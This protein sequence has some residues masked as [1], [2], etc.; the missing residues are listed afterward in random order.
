MG[1]WAGGSI[2]ALRE[3]QLESARPSCS[4]RAPEVVFAQHMK[5]RMHHSFDHRSEQD[6][7]RTPF[8]AMWAGLK[9]LLLVLNVEECC[10]ASAWACMDIGAVCT[11][12]GMKQGEAHDKVVPVSPPEGAKVGERITVAGYD[13]APIEEVNPKKKILERLF[14]DMRTNAGA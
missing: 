6:A 9:E 3:D 11:Y 7:A 5:A 12:K 4:A 10:S 8:L 14:P 1:E 2:Q 13:Q